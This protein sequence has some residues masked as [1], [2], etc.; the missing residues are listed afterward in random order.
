MLMRMLAPLCTIGGDIN[1]WNNHYGKNMK[2]Q[3]IIL[4]PVIQLLGIYS[5]TTEML[6]RS[7]SVAMNI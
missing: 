7:D 5:K 6:T 3:K 4:S 2:I 1:W